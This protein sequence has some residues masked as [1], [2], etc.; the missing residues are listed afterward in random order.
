MTCSP[1]LVGAGPCRGC[2]EYVS[3]VP[4][5]VERLHLVD[6]GDELRIYC[7]RCC[8]ECGS[9]PPAE[10]QDAPKQDNRTLDTRSKHSGHDS[11][12]GVVETLQ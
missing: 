3:S 12:L 11:R 5:G 10:A 4:T 1:H 2:G 7:P 6:T 8:P 9:L